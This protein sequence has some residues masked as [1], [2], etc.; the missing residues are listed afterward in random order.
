MPT[1]VKFRS[2]IS[3]I[4]DAVTF[5]CEYFSCKYSQLILFVRKLL[6]SVFAVLQLCGM[7][8]YLYLLSYHLSCRPFCENGAK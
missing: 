6:L 3:T 1:I 8:T 7:T 2:V 4:V 5:V